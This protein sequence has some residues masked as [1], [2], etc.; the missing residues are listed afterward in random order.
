MSEFTPNA[1][2]AKIFTKCGQFDHLHEELLLEALQKIELQIQVHSSCKSIHNANPSAA[3]G[4][5][6]INATNGSLVQVYCD[7]EGANCGGEGGWTRVA[8]VD[9]TK[10]GATC[11]QG[12]EQ[13]AFN[14]VMYCGRFSNGS[15][16]VSAVVDNIISYRQVC[17]RVLGYQ[18]GGPDAFDLFIR[19]N[20]SINQVYFDGL[21]I[22]YGVPCRHIWTYT[23]GF[24]EEGIQSHECPCNTGSTQSGPPCIGNDYYCE[25]GGETCVTEELLSS[26]ILWD[27]QQ[28]GGREAPCCTHPNM[29]WFIKT[30]NEITT[31][32]LELRACQS[33]YVCFGSVPIFLIELY[34]R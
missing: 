25:S 5:Y 22:M 9:M 4:Y 32:D 1:F 34:V 26:D 21:T 30:L 7:M 16:C 33:N 20:A 14:G 31:D 17:G 6:H 24:S 11:P 3:S 12:L 15:G 27:G 23:A 2:P 28:C 8:F 19:T 13:M 18:R 10:T 29:P